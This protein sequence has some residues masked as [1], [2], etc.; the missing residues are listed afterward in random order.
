MTNKIVAISD[1]HLGQNGIDGLGQYSL[2]STKVPTNLVQQFVASVATFAAGDPITLLVAG[3]FL[4]LSLAYAEDALN[5]LSALLGAFVGKVRVDEIVYVVG[6]HDQHL[7]SLHSEDKQLLGPLRAGLVPS[8]GD[9]PGAK[10]MYQVTSA[11]GESFSLLQP[12]VNRVF[13]PPPPKVM[14]AYPSYVR[15]LDASS[16]L[17]VTHGHLFGGLYTEMSSLIKNKLAGLP[18][19]HVVATVNQPL[20]EFIYWLLGE[21]GEGIGADGLVEEIYTD[22]QKGTLSR[23][24]G[25]VANAVTQILPHGVLWRVIGGLERKIVV[26]AV[27]AALTKVLLSPG[28][29]DNASADRFA[30]LATTRAGLVAWLEAVDWPK[31]STIVLYG[32]T[33][34]WDDY[35]IPGT[36]A[37]SYNLC[38]WLVEPKH[39]IPKT[40]FLGIDGAIA[41]WIDVGQS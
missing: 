15:Q 14:I 39:P 24:R 20:I 26:D 19:D 17:Y 34:V 13:A 31:Q 33:H 37:H 38:T 28:A 9:A 10:A 36:G 23:V 5:D 32:H 41:R 8:N 35:P 30:D 3:D 25:I 27:M 6:N 4:D 40:G 12:L 16:V 29:S 1:P 18:H 11:L 21:T 7:W 22:I 2:L